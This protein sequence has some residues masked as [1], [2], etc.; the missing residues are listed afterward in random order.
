MTK[1]GVR[2]EYG[3]AEIADFIGS[4]IENTYCPCFSNEKHKP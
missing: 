4:K 1:R 2:H 3:I